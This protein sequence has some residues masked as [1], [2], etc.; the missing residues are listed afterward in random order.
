VSEPGEIVVRVAAP[1]AAEAMDPRVLRTRAAVVQAATALFLERG[2]VD[3]S[4]DDVAV[5]ASVSKKT[6]YNNFGDKERLFTEIVLGV[7]ATAEDFAGRVTEGFADGTDVAELLHDLARRH[8]DSV[9]GPAVVQ[10]RRLVSAESRR[11][12]DLARE[13]YRRAPTRVIAAIAETFT[14]LNARGVLRIADPARAAEHFAF[15]VVG[16]SLDRIMFE[17]SAAVPRA[18]E[19]DRIARA[20]VITFLAAYGPGPGV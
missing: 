4:L 2:Y 13:Y 20:A 1:D 5:R 16:P 14:H 11:F 18:E 17:G 19:R 9:T 12:P 10:V 6:I 15:L 3:T 7:T 8:L